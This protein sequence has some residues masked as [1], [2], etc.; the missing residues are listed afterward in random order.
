LARHAG[1]KQA[2]STRTYHHHVK[3]MGQIDL[4]PNVD[5]CGKL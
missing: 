1:A 3:F 2:G 5:G 4:Q